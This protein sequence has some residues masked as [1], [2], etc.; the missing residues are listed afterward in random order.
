MGSR[1]LASAFHCVQPCIKEYIQRP[2][3]HV[4]CSEVWQWALHACLFVY[5]V[6]HCC[7]HFSYTCCTNSGFRYE[8]P[9]N[10]VWSKFIMNNLSVGVRSVFS[11]VNCLSKLLTSLRCFYKLY[12]ILFISSWNNVTLTIF[13]L[14]GGCTSLFSIRSQSIRRKN[15]CPLTSS[16][17]LAPQPSLLFG[18]FVNSWKHNV[19]TQLSRDYI[20]NAR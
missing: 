9:M 18:F 16:S 10:S 3:V 11:D 17:P 12:K 15:A 7:V 8:N 13:G 6:M 4:W 20:V 5:E 1:L 14:N 19:H 2:E